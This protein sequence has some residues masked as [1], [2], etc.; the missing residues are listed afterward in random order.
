MQSIFN[1][2]QTLKAESLG[3][4]EGFNIASL[5]TM[6]HHKIGVSG[7]GQPMF[8]IRCDNSEKASFLDSNLELIAVQFDRECQLLTNKQKMEEGIYTIIYLKT[9]SIDLQEYFLEI[10]FLIIKKLN[11]IPTLQELKIEVE[12]LIE[13]FSKFSKPPTKTVQGLWAELLVIEQSKNPA[14]L[15]QSWHNSATDKFDFND[16][17]DKIEVKSTSKDR[18]VHSFSIEQLH[19]NQNSK[20]IISSIVVVETGIGKNIFDLVN[21]IESKVKDREL[22][23]RINEII[24]QTLGNCLS[25]SFELYFDYQLAIDSLQFYDCENIPKIDLQTIPIE[26]SNVRFDSDLTN[27]QPIKKN[28]TKS[29]LH[30]SLF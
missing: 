9:D 29:I 11:S 18:R 7:N 17:I 15:I 16:G 28:K 5:P 22:Q 23:F 14:Y 13:L 3:G 27:I 25:K 10:I 26:V 8:F 2:F 21:L 20:L 19:P 1:I 12:K 30:N 6:R 4:V 24:A